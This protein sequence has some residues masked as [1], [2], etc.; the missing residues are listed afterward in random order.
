MK[1]TVLSFLPWATLMML[2]V[3]SVPKPARTAPVPP[4]PYPRIHA[5][6]NALRDSRTE[7]EHAGNDFC[8]HKAEALEQ[9]DRA[10]RQ[11]QEAMDCAGR[12]R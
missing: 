6:L 12:R 10:I 1:K 5:A 11:L 3:I 7:M 4:P 2:A 8:G 9:C